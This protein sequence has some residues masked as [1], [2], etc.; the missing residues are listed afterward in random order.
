MGIIYMCMF[1]LVCDISSFCVEF[2]P[3]GLNIDTNSNIQGMIEDPV[4]SPILF[5]PGYHTVAK[6]QDQIGSN[7]QTCT[8]SGHI[9]MLMYSILVPTSYDLPM[10]HLVYP[11]FNFVA[12]F[13][14][15]FHSLA[16][17]TWIPEFEGF[18]W[19]S[20]CINDNQIVA[21]AMSVGMFCTQHPTSAASTAANN[22]D[23]TSQEKRGQGGGR[24]RQMGT[25]RFEIVWG[26]IPSCKALFERMHSVAWCFWIPQHRVFDVGYAVGKVPSS[27]GSWC[28]CQL[29][30][31]GCSVISSPGADVSRFVSLIQLSMSSIH[32]V[33][34]SL[35]KSCKRKRIGLDM[36][37]RKAVQL[38]VGGFNLLERWWTM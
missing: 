34:S 16:N 19:I 32:V 10:S 38:L 11:G 13:S 17:Q 4:K 2:V 14:G 3:E 24:H 1:K 20:H 5:G 12:Y 9:M 6:L 25:F 37:G 21:D 8:G 26:S 18:W 36:I 27:T 23:S 7:Y 15:T 22:F 31:V 33:S 30:R 35:S 28:N 29:F